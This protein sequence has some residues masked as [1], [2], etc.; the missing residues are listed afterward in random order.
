MEVTLIIEDPQ[1]KVIAETQTAENGDYLVALSGGLNYSII[2]KEKDYVSV[3]ESV[4]VP[5]SGSTSLIINRSFLLEE[6]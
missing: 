4:Y 3:K 2:I 1:G 6:Q 5:V